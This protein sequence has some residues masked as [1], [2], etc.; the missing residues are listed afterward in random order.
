[1][2]DFFSLAVNGTKH[3]G[4][5]YELVHVLSNDIGVIGI[6]SDWSATVTYYANCFVLS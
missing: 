6:F 2:A 1:M 4:D 5:I 3:D